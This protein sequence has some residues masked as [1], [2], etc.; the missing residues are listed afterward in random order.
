MGLPPTVCDSSYTLHGLPIDGRERLTRRFQER[1]G[2]P[3]NLTLE[4]CGSWRPEVLAALVRREED[5]RGLDER[6][7]AAIRRDLHRGDAGLL[8]AARYQSTGL[9]AS[10]SYWNE[11]RTVGTSRTQ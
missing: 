8:K 1:Q 4:V 3:H 2:L 10:W 5:A 6:A 9:M 7:W 11:D